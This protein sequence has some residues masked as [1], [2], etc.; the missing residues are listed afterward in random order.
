MGVGG[1]D[2]GPSGQKGRE[3][4]TGKDAV[5]DFL[6]H[7]PAD[8]GGAIGARARRWLRHTDP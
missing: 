4:R 7:V 3:H 6:L 2:P 5:A 1:Q 8:Q